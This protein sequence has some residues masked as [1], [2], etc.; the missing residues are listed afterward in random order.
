MMLGCKEHKLYLIVVFNILI[1][2]RTMS[3]H[4]LKFSTIQGWRGCICIQYYLN[5]RMNSTPIH[6]LQ[7]SM[8][9]ELSDFML[10]VFIVANL[11]SQY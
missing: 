9:R 11:K 2:V 1:E 4:H 10:L 5:V 7:G 3:T 6:S 8:S